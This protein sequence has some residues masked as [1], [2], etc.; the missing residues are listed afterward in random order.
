MTDP[1]HHIIICWSPPSSLPAADLIVL[2]LFGWC[3]GKY[4]CTITV[5]VFFRYR[6]II[7]H[8]SISLSLRRHMTMT[9]INTMPYDTVF[10]LSIDCFNRAGRARSLSSFIFDLLFRCFFCLPRPQMNSISFL[11]FAVCFVLISVHC[12]CCQSVVMMFCA[13][14]LS[15]AISFISTRANRNLHRFAK[16]STAT[17]LFHVIRL[18]ASESPPLLLSSLITHNSDSTAIANG[19]DTRICL[20]FSVLTRTVTRVMPHSAAPMSGFMIVCYGAWVY[21]CCV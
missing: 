14:D 6:Y 7:S 15:I 21:S 20:I 8:H 9:H 4:Q 13:C 3:T 12:C 19:A 18:D 1:H 11:T 16:Q 10:C 17:D 5:L 2:L